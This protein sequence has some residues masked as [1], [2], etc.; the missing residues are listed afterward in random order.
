[1]S[2]S[3]SFLSLKTM[4]ALWCLERSSSANLNAYSFS[5]SE[6][7]MR[8]YSVRAGLLM[9]SRSCSRRM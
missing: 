5:S 1:M 7:G 2:L 9:W 4:V 3:L 8:A 6:T